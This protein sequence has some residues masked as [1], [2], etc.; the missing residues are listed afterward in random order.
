NND[1]NG[2]KPQRG[3]V[4][5]SLGL[6][7]TLS[8]TTVFYA[9]FEDASGNFAS[10][11]FT[12]NNTPLRSS[13]ATGLW[14]PSQGRGNQPGHSPTWSF[15][16]GQGEGPN[17]GGN[18]QTDGKANGGYLISPSITL[19]KDSIISLGF[20]YVL[21]TENFA[22][23]DLAQLQVNAGGGWSTLA[24]YNA[25][26]DSPGWRAV[27]PVDLSAYAGKS[28]QLR[29]YF[30]TVDQFFNNFEGWYVD[31][32]KIDATP[33][34][35]DY[36]IALGSGDSVTIGVTALSP[37]GVDVS[38]LDAS[39][40]VVAT[41]Q[42]GPN[43][44]TQVIQDFVAPGSGT[45]SRQVG[46][47]PGPAYSVAA[48]QNPAFSLPPNSTIATA[49]PILAPQEA[50]RQWVLG[51]VNSQQQVIVPYADSGWYTS[52]GNHTSSNK[53]YLTA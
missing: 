39:G 19:P 17:G 53:N 46:G 44:V 15:Y 16:Y 27:S 11:G 32:V 12:V 41:S 30:D 1:G 24:S 2:P 6:V 14:H 36:S 52:L 40:N 29:W 42:A 38:L 10:D 5:G 28:V 13:Y 49:Q 8:T 33:V 20:D 31:D 48:T 7:S 4:L 18:Y 51:Y 26:G 45:Y 47:R 3:A 50:A 37:G 21:Q 43:N 25:I 22:P 9:P 23:F 35:D 34:H